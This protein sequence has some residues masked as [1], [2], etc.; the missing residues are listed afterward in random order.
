MG[1]STLKAPEFRNGVAELQAGGRWGL[2]NRNG[3]WFI[4]PKFQA[5][6][7]FTDIGTC[8]R[9]S[10]KWAIAD[11]EG[12]LLCPPTFD[13]PVDLTLHEIGANLLAKS[14]GLTG[15]INSRGKWI[16]SPQFDVASN[17]GEGISSVSLGGLHG[18]IDETGAYTAPLSE[19]DYLGR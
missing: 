11:S 8:V 7:V 12:K 1:H 18:L 3:E 17:F 15:F 6:E 16:I 2:V 9:K 5:V 10:G 14:N 19:Y 4:R 13:S